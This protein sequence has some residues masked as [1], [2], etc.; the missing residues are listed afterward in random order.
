M[1]LLTA[2]AAFLKEHD[3]STTMWEHGYTQ[4]EANDVCHAL[5]TWATEA[6][7][8]TGE[9]IMLWSMRDDL[10]FSG[11]SELAYAV[12]GCAYLFPNPFI[13]GDAEGFLS[14]LQNV[15]NGR[16]DDLYQAPIESRLL[17]NAV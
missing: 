8:L 17:Y 14:A 9:F 13:E 2:F 12:A 1:S 11:D 6:Q 3:Y 7:G 15:M 4:D 16:L 10:S 5:T